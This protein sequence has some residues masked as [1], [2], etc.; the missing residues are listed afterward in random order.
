M[1]L[2]DS[3]PRSGMV[4]GRGR[5]QHRAEL[6]PPFG[7]SAL[8]IHGGPEDCWQVH[9]IQKILEDKQINLTLVRQQGEPKVEQVDL[10]VQKARRAECEFVIGLGGGSAIDSA[11]A[12]AGLLTNG[13]SALDFLGVV[14]R[15]KK[16]TRPAPRGVAIPPT[17]AAR[18]E[19]PRTTPAP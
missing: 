10:I 18:P 14:G 2:L 5:F 12:V 8:M 11:K 19:G 1:N 13:G 3:N 15:G 9:F 6:G 4:F 7:S 16:I 17:A